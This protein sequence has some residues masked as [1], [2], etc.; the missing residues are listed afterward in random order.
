MR[1]SAVVWGWGRGSGEMGEVEV[2]LVWYGVV[3][4]SCLSDSRF[5]E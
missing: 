5:I 2:G 4:V 3:N 1:G